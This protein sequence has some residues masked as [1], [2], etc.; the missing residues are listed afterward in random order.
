MS[1]LLD[2]LKKAEAAKRAQQAEQQPVAASAPP[3]VSARSGLHLRLSDEGDQPL[4]P[5]ATEPAAITANGSGLSLAGD[6]GLLSATPPLPSLPDLPPLPSALP[7][8]SAASDFPSLSVGDHAELPHVDD[9]HTVSPLPSPN[10]TEAAFPSLDALPTPAPSASVVDAP[11]LDFVST[12]T[13]TPP[14]AVTQDLSALTPPASSEPDFLPE[15]PATTAKSVLPPVPEVVE[16]S[17]P[18]EKPSEVRESAPVDQKAV[19]RRIVAAG[20]AK[21][22]QPQMGMK[23]FLKPIPLALMTVGV[24]ALAFGGFWFWSEM[25]VETPM[26]VVRPIVPTP[27]VATAEAEPAKEE[28]PPVEED[29]DLLTQLDAGAQAPALP[30]TDPVLAKANAPVKPTELFQIHAG[31]DGNR[32]IS[33]A[34]HRAPNASAIRNAPPAPPVSRAR[35]LGRQAY[36]A[37][38]QGDLPR[39]AALYQEALANTPDDAEALLGLAAVLAR[40]GAHAD[41]MQL[42]RQVLNTRPT[43]ASALAGLAA[44]GGSKQAAGLRQ[45]NAVAA[46]QMANQ[47]AAQ[48]QWAQAQEHYFKAYTLAPNQPDYAFNLA[49]SLDHLGVRK[50][51]KGYYSKALALTEQGQSASF[52]REQVRRRIHELQPAAEPA[53]DTP[54]DTEASQ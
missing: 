47:Y 46:F 3:A 6:D 22:T 12:L 1:L 23:R 35:D 25:M 41:A 49:V 2:A 39:S 50:E 8:S 24:S 9:A 28:E 37:W 29:K 32:V 13:P 5:P 7:T 53:L 51:A 45:P 43:D 33:I 14:P 48:N 30:P 52:D 31:A 19:A 42:Y 26:Q 21:Q 40:Q 11:P 38:Q 10:A 36:S 16:A 54:T 20:K 4:S 34:G 27:P 18:S 15:S 44:L 17:K